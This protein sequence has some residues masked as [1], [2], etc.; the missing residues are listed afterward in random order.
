M[1]TY[2]E[3]SRSTLWESVVDAALKAGLQAVVEHLHQQGLGARM[4]A[5]CAYLGVGQAALLIP[6]CQFQSAPSG[7]LH[8]ANIQ[9]ALRLGEGRPLLF[10]DMVAQVGRSREEA[11]T[12]AL[13]QVWLHGDLPPILA[14]IGGPRLPELEVFD[15][16]NELSCPPWIIYAGPHQLSGPH[17]EQ[18]AQTLVERPP[19]LM[20]RELLG[21]HVDPTRPHWLK[22]FRCRDEESGLDQA[23]CLLDFRQLEHGRRL[24]GE[25]PWPSVNG[26]HLFRQFLVLLPQERELGTALSDLE[27]SCTTPQ[28]AV[29]RLV[30]AIAARPEFT[31]DEVYAA[32]ANAG[33][34][35]P[36]ADRAYKFTQ[37]AW[38]R[39]LLDGLG[40]NFAP[41]Y[42]CF[43]G[44]GDVIESGQLSEEPYFAAAMAAAKQHPPPAGLPRMALKSADVS[45]VNSALHAGSKP[46]N[47]VMSPAAL[48]LEA[49][50]P[51]GIEK[52]RQTLSQHVGCVQPRRGAGAP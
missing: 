17:R 10:E 13:L 5:E 39:V 43:N 41:D 11:A 16:G 46:E 2:A 48:F 31:E 12:S 1:D 50:T 26:R 47:L 15:R 4:G 52:A 7:D 21:R 30:D 19:L 45:A 25:W 20:L 18:F 28:A 44:A 34:P 37:V 24:L 42:L 38:G 8:S 29:T 6:W 40:I 33:I 23:D 14:L 35:E 32:M 51:A 9:V 22:L 36:V 27:G 49:A 3:H